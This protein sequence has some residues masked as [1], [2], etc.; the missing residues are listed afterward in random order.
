MSSRLPHVTRL[1]EQAF[2]D[3]PALAQEADRLGEQGIGHGNTECALSI[4]RRAPVD[5]WTVNSAADLDLSTLDGRYQLG[6][7][8]GQWATR[9]IR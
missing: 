3:G 7:R 2:E 8:V 4:Q 1:F 6:L 5:P 9:G